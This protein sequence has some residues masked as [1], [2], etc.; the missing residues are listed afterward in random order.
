V[1][2]AGLD[3]KD[4]IREFDRTVNSKNE[5]RAVEAFLSDLKIRFEATGV[6]DNVVEAARGGFSECV[7]PM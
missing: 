2:Q 5:L 7:S 4:A 1:R 6:L 3:P